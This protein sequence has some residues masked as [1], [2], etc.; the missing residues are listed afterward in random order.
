MNILDNHGHR[1]VPRVSEASSFQ[2]QSSLKQV[3]HDNHFG[4]FV[5]LVLRDIINITHYY[6]GALIHEY[7]ILANTDVGILMDG[8]NIQRRIVVEEYYDDR[9]LDPIGCLD[10][11]S[12][13]YGAIAVLRLD[14][15]VVFDNYIKPIKLPDVENDEESIITL[16]RTW[17]FEVS[18]K[19][20]N[21]S[22]VNK[23]PMS[24]KE[25]HS[26]L[27]EACGPNYPKTMALLCEE[28]LFSKDIEKDEVPGLFAAIAVDLNISEL[29]YILSYVESKH[30]NLNATFNKVYA[31]KGWINE[32]MFNY[33][34][35]T[36]STTT[37]SAT[38]ITNFTFVFLL[39]LLLQLMS[40]LPLLLQ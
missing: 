39:L 22:Y 13:C 16:S 27:Q 25:S 1:T 9:F 36:T 11:L 23:K 32:I 6:Q 20:V 17:P 10:I 28:V 8:A 38:S 15:P 12:F 35:T 30:R 24:C 2:V 29:R 7:F 37:A 5:E 18:M 33:T 31:F 4:F 14:R 3:N 26:A 19:E 21:Y 40:S 34:S